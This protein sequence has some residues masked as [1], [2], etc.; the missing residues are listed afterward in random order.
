MT[1]YEIAKLN[2]QYYGNSLPSE[3]YDEVD[4]NCVK[5]ETQKY[6]LQ[7]D[8]AL[9]G[10]Y[11]IFI[12]VRNKTTMERYFLWVLSH[13]T[14]D[15][16]VG[17]LIEG[18]GTTAKQVLVALMENELDGYAQQIYNAE[19]GTIVSSIDSSVRGRYSN[20]LNHEGGCKPYLQSKGEFE[21]MMFITPNTD[22]YYWPFFLTREV[23]G[24]VK[25][26]LPLNVD[27]DFNVS[28]HTIW[29]K[30]TIEIGVDEDEENEYENK[31]EEIM[32][33]VI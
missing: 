24:I 20:Y 22:T 25:Y 33:K 19:S 2:T 6:D 7:V 30:T 17:A 12:G 3:G 9:E 18:E 11:T 5:E 29:S 13:N 14:T 26:E 32:E 8:D 21:W 10:N 1:T 28:L 27:V 23:F 15:K 4:F 16:S 31:I